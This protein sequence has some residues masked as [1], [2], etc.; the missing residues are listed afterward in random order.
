MQTEKRDRRERKERDVEKERKR[1]GRRGPAALAALLLIG[2]ALCLPCS[3]AEEPGVYASPEERAAIAEMIGAN[4]DFTALLAALGITVVGESVTPVY[5]VDLE[6][7]GA[8]GELRPEPVILA[9]RGGRVYVAKTLDAA[10]EYGGNLKFSV[11]DGAAEFLGFTPSAAVS[12]GEVPGAWTP[13]S[14]FWADHAER[15]RT[16]LGL[17]EPIP[18]EAVLYVELRLGSG[19]LVRCGEIEVIVW[20]GYEQ[21]PEGV[22]VGEVTEVRGEL[23]EKAV[24]YRREAEERRKEHP[25]EG[26]SATG[27]STGGADGGAAAPAA[28]GQS[29]KPRARWAA[30]LS[31]VLCAAL[32]LAA[33]AAVFGIVRSRRRG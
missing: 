30:Q 26:S 18:E 6:D 3:G 10:G 15:A 2:A 32:V 5:A 21:V 4:E 29:P 11:A 28:A 16:L 13:A 7:F 19:F 12:E 25:G 24:E 9:D 31:L 17:T 22:P 8:T 20:Q 27:G 33:A 23:L 14:C 1:T